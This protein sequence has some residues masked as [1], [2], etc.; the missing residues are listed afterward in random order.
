MM[1]GR[2]FDSLT[3]ISIVAEMRQHLEG[4]LEAQEGGGV[5]NAIFSLLS[6]VRADLENSADD[7]DDHDCDTR[8]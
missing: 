1:N 6:L 5:Q 4:A 3:L 8:L 2:P 7:N